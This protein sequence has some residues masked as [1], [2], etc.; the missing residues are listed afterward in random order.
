MERV[1]WSTMIK[2]FQGASHKR[3]Y[4]QLAN[5]LALYTFVW[6]VGFY[7]YQLS[8]WLLL[9]CALLAQ[10]AYVR[11]F[12]VLHDCGHGSF[13]NKKRLRSFWGSICGILTFTPYHQWTAEHAAH[14]KTSGNLAHRGRGDIWTMTVDEY[15][16]ASTLQKICY[17]IYRFPP[18]MLIGGGLFIFVI[19]HRFTTKYDGPKEKKSVYLT[20]LGILALG[21]GISWA[22]SWQFY[23][24]FQLSVVV[25]AGIFGIG[26]FYVQHQFDG[27]Y[28]G[29]ADEWDYEQA[30]L[31][32]CS[33]LKLPKILQWASGNIGFHHIHH[34][35]PLIPNYRL[36]QV[37]DRFAIFQAKEVVLE[38]KDLMR[39]FQLS[40]YDHKNKRMLRFR[41][42]KDPIFW[43]ER[44][45]A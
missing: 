37:Y 12:I 20:N 1:N 38:L 11:I 10:L 17:R 43:T 33:Y 23:L 19:Y 9:P 35:S 45:V 25:M 30:A 14:H 16:Q 18:F 6:V 13:F 21:L 26:L 36:E 32:G 2:P 41:D 22:T 24:L 8:A 42:L 3:S 31:K 5:S 39:C 4:W 40:L 7:A 34:L 15:C 27:V 44:A 29:E 28:W